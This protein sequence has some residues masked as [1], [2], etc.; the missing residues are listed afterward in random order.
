MS[1]LFTKY[2]FFENICYLNIPCIRRNNKL[3]RVHARVHRVRRDPFHSD[4]QAWPGTERRR[5]ERGRRLGAKEERQLLE[6][7]IEI[8]L[9]YKLQHFQVYI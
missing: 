4:G 3:V 5:S 9:S 8:L 1:R 2:V 7:I 6:H